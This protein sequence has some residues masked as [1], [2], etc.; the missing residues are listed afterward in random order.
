LGISANT[1]KG[2]YLHIA[3][4]S[5]LACK[6]I[7]VLGGIVDAGY[8]GN[9]SVILF[10]TSNKEITFTSGDRIAQIIPTKI[11]LPTLVQT[12][13]LDSTDRGASGFGSSGMGEKV[14]TRIAAVKALK[15]ELRTEPKDSYNHDT[16]LT[17]IAEQLL[18]KHKAS[19]SKAAHKALAKYHLINGVLYKK[20]R[21][22]VSH[23][24]DKEILLNEFHDS[25]LS[26]HP[27]IEKTYA[28]MSEL[29]YWPNMYNDVVEY[30]RTC[31]KCQRIKASHQPS[32]GPL[33]PLQI[34]RKN[35]E[36]ISMDFITHLPETKAG[37]N[38]ILV[39]VD[40]L[41]KM[42]HFIA[43]KDTATAEEVAKLIFDNIVKLHGVPETI[44]S[45]RDPKFTALFWKNLWK[46][47][48]TS[49]SMSTA[50]HPQT[51]GQTER[52]NQSLEEMLRATCNHHQDNWDNLLSYAEFAYNS[53]KH[54]STKYSPFYINYGY[55]PT[56]PIDLTL[57]NDMTKGES[58]ELVKQIKIV[59]EEVISNLEH[60]QL[61]MIE[62][63]D[64]GLK[65]PNIQVGDLVKLSTKHT[66]P[67]Y[68]G[69]R[70][71]TSLQHKWSG[72]YKVM[73]RISKNAYMLDLPKNMKI[74]PVVSW[75]HLEKY[76]S[77]KRFNSRIVEPPPPVEIANHLEYEVEAIIS[78]RKRYKR[79]EYLVHWV[80]YGEDQR[81]WEP[82]SAL[83]NAKLILETYKNK[84]KLN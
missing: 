2:T 28:A 51:D 18:A 48:G 77:T 17:R 66:K 52:V 67:P 23:K 44:I 24:E 75:S 15:T 13:S 43:T 80:G 72:P 74:H 21:R 64:K 4:R 70:S 10:N 40:R 34:P 39:V 7:Q 9:I 69:N 5:G 83:A 61:K 1:P 49:L 3:P 33:Q 50:G 82:E 29:F 55:E 25:P 65:P 20:G 38:S 11:E 79:N 45:D 37:Y 31:D 71:N 59:N 19:N 58:P 41:S 63:H 47:L 22:C 46:I 30:V 56:R 81:T 53:R 68:L 60:A 76:N 42:S 14:L 78:H 26:L 32:D 6:G 54:S 36:S 27:G 62:Y 73:E 35:W 12:D 84:H 57:R 16:S 8:T